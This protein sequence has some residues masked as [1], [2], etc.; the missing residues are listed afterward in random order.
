[1]GRC[2]PDTSATTQWGFDLATLSIIHP[3]LSL[4]LH[5]SLSSAI[6]AFICPS[7]PSSS[8]PSIIHPSICPPDPL[9]PHPSI[10]HSSPSIPLFLHPRIHPSFCPFIPLS[11][12]PSFIPPSLPLSVHPS[13]TAVPDGVMDGVPSSPCPYVHHSFLHPPIPLS[14]FLTAKLAPTAL[15]HQIMLEVEK[16][17]S[18]QLSINHC[19]WRPQHV[20]PTFIIGIE[21]PKS[22]GFARGATAKCS[23]DTASATNLLPLVVLLNHFWHSSSVT[24]DMVMLD[25]QRQKKKI[26]GQRDG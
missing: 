5:P 16:Q 19:F 9:S 3:S 20:P 22:E 8:S 10:H 23:T 2:C 11:L 4:S 7:V 12:Y 24:V 26:N 13:L 15:R 18:W 21:I 17:S 25:D 6:H 1:M 14:P